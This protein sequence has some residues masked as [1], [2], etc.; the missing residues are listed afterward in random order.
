V[1]DDSDPYT[2][3][4]FTGRLIERFA[5]AIGAHGT[6]T[7]GTV[8]GGG[9][10]DPRYKGMA[11][12]ATIVSQYFSDILVN[13]PTYMTDYIWCSPTILIPLPVRVVPMKESTMCC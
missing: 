1:G 6:H 10:L 3:V 5:P 9:I 7:S 12:N 11:L 8:G 13:A 4:D 2:H